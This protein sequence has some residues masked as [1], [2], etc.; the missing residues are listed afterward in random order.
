M[1]VN[2]RRFPVLTCT[3]LWWETPGLSSPRGGVSFWGPQPISSFNDR[4]LPTS[5]LSFVLSRDCRSSLRSGLSSRVLPTRFSEV[6][7]V[8]L[9]TGSFR[10]APQSCCHLAAGKGLAPPRRVQGRGLPPRR[11]LQG[12]RVHLVAF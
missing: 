8:Y 7:C 4:R 10:S 11:L 5:S 3:C 6:H 2:V 12:R 1:T 9:K